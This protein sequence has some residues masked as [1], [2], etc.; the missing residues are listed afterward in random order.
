MILGTRSAMFCLFL[1]L[2]LGGLETGQSVSHCQWEDSNGRCKECRHN[3]YLYNGTCVQSCPGGFFERIQHDPYIFYIPAIGRTCEKK[4]EFSAISWA[5]S[6][7]AKPNF[8]GKILTVVYTDYAIAALSLDGSVQVSGHPLY[9]GT[10]PQLS[11]NVKTLYG[12]GYAFAALKTDGGVVSWGSTG[13]EGWGHPISDP[14]LTSGVSAIFASGFAF[15]AL[16][17]DGTVAAWGQACCGGDASSVQSDL[18]NVETIFVT[19]HS[20]A[21]LKNDGS[22]VTW[23][24]AFYGGNDPGIGAGSGIE[25]VFSDWRSFVFLKTDGTVLK[26]HGGNGANPPSLTGSVKAIVGTGEYGWAALDSNG[27]VQ[28][29]GTYSY[30]PLFSAN[31]TFFN[32]PDPNLSSGV[33]YITSTKRAFAA[34][35]ADGSV[36]VWGSPIYG[37]KDPGLTSNVVDIYANEHAFS[38]LLANGSVVSWGLPHNGGSGAAGLSSNVKAVIPR[39]SSFTAIKTDG[40]VVYWGAP[41]NYP[42]MTGT[43][44][45]VVGVYGNYYGMVFLYECQSTIKNAMEWHCCDPQTNGTF[46]R[47]FDCLLNDKVSLSGD[48]SLA[49]NASNLPTI[50][51]AYEKR[52]FVVSNYTLTLR[53]LKLTGLNQTHTGGIRVNGGT[54]ITFS[55][56]FTL[57]KADIGGVAH[58]SGGGAV[59][60]W[61]TNATENY[62][63]GS[64]ST[65]GSGGVITLNGAETTLTVIGGRFTSNQVNAEE[66]F[67]H[68]YQY[69]QGGAVFCNLIRE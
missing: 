20:M 67:F 14:G 63:V 41:N 30:S 38:A 24:H 48:L 37:G 25:T 40:T 2:V 31:Y 9:G 47:S 64:S 7:F 69:I 29:F 22:V 51:A 50:T 12:T 13:P 44:G 8:K 32:V 19:S 66:T 11:S 42:C 59:K 23:G 55:C 58:A 61:D 60:M 28:C 18:T 62:A 6:G 4:Q 43:D 26:Q 65:V 15:A 39:R 35:K 5:S 49:G 52:H 34:L 57:N 56:W 17:T 1:L 3:R 10:D 27:G 68:T 21:A 54:L 36:T 33:I 16:K 53:W 46:N 45:N